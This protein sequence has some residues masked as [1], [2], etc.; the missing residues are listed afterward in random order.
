LGGGFGWL[1]R[2]HGLTIDNLRSADVVTADGKLVTASKTENPDLFWGI[3]GGGGN[4]GV[5]TSFELDV[6]PVGPEVLS[7]LVVHPYSAAREVMSFYRDFASDLA[8]D[9]NVWSRSSESTTR[10]TSS[11]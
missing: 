5:V 3:R 11:A 4:F 10:T 9:L 8:E 7:G 2:K 1:S 6:H